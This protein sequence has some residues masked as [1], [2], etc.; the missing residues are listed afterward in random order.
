[1]STRGA[2]ETERFNTMMKTWINQFAHLLQSTDV[3]DHIE[4]LIIEPF[5]NYI[6]GRTFPYMILAFCLFGAIFLFVILTFVL[7]LMRNSPV[8]SQM[9]CA[10]CKAAAAGLGVSI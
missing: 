10:T 6:L 1:M 7:L 3:K 9:T 2:K 5:M 8:P 4:G